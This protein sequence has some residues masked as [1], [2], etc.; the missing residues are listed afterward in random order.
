[1]IDD[2]KKWGY[3][4]GGLG[5]KNQ[6][7]SKYKIQSLATTSP[8][9]FMSFKQ[10]QESYDDEIHAMGINP[11]EWYEQRI[12]EME[13]TLNKVKTT[14]GI[15][16]WRCMEVKSDFIAKLQAGKIK[17]LGFC[18]TI[19]KDAAP[20]LCGGAADSDDIDENNIVLEAEI[21]FDQLDLEKIL[22]P[23]WGEDEFDEQEV[24][25]KKYVLLHCVLDGLA[26]KKLIH[27]SPPKKCLV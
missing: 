3:V 22:D 7:E 18:W 17:H 8:F 26:E 21:P 6:L 27:F 2:Y 9:K 14:Q 23:S 15:M 16:A 11:K 25:P 5:F 24:N 1:M 20:G 19:N 13:K 4:R 12:K 10:W